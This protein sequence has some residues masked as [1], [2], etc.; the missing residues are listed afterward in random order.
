M[1]ERLKTIGVAAGILLVFGSLWIVGSGL[2]SDNY[3]FGV[4]FWLYFSIVLT[5][6]V[7]Y[8]LLL[9]IETLTR[10]NTAQQ[11]QIDDLKRELEEIKQKLNQ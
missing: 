8:T 5:L 9:P 4:G 3:K 1:Q 2:I 7:F 10:K 11:T 6:T